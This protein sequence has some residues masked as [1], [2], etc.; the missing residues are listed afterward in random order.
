MKSNS[1]ASGFTAIEALSM[2][3]TLFVFSMIVGSLWIRYQKDPASM[4]SLSGLSDS[5]LGKPETGPTAAPQTD[6]KGPVGNP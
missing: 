2:I 1:S 3:A 4:P 5:P 6:T